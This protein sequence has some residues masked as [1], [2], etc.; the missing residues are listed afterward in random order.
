MK[1]R[2]LLVAL[3]LLAAPLAAEPPSAVAI[4]NA[5]IITVSGATLDRGSVVLRNGL[6]ESVGAS[7]SIP[8]DAW[9]VEG[10]G[11]TV[12]PG[13]IDALSTVGLNT[14]TPTIQTTGRRGGGPPTGDPAPAG[15]VSR[16]PE[17][18]PLNTSYLL[19]A[20]QITLADRRI[21]SYRNMGF[22][23]AVSFPTR[24]IFA[25]Q[26]AVIN[27][28]G[29]RPSAMVI[30]PSAGLYLTM[31]PNG[32]GGGFPNSLMGVI[33]Y[34]RQIYLD[35]G[36]Y[37]EA[38]AIYAAHPAGNKRP[39]YDKTLEGVLAATRILL[40]A[41]NPKEIHRMLRFAT[42]LK[43]KALLYG[44]Q[45]GFLATDVLKARNAAV[46]LN[47]R[48]PERARD[49]D[50]EAVES[51]RALE[52]RDKA[53]TTAAALA[54]AGVPFA[55]YLGGLER[56]SEINAAIRKAMAAGLTEAD[57]IKALTLSAARLFGVDDRLGSIE[58]GKIANL[59]VT[60][61]PL[62]EDR[63]EMKYVFVD[64]VKYEPAPAPAAPASEATR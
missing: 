19:A 57:A 40:P 26:G 47:L 53:P 2:R 43:Q 11:L 25:G 6:I 63:T 1:T 64:G 28:S 60:K 51:M 20:D 55:F 10:E 61:G 56:A 4:R 48:W 30:D 17:D 44:L 32:F 54:K 22:T 8:A 62:F 16:G 39:E 23:S 18:R 42:E 50:P 41:Q 24:G 58:P 14:P 59:V 15:P 36:Q 46:L 9:V 35:A 13:L 34:I 37:K 27:L 12:Y 45:E 52:F 5:R 31:R 38:K 49:G 21:E 33:A 7:T 29:Q 3:A